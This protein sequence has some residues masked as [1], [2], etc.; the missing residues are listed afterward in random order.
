METIEQRSDFVQLNFFHVISGT[1]MSMDLQ[2]CVKILNDEDSSVEEKYEALAFISENKQFYDMLFRLGIITEKNV[3]KIGTLNML[4]D[5]IISMF[6][7]LTCVLY[8]LQ[9][10]VLSNFNLW[11]VTMMKFH[12]YKWKN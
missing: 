10:H 2:D 5:I 3:F 12:C 11:I 1:Q 9:S 4:L 7:C 8:S 6:I